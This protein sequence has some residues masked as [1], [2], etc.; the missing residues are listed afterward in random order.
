MFTGIVEDIGK[1]EYIRGNS[2]SV[3]TA[4]KDI[5]QGDSLLV[6]GVCLTVTKVSV[7]RVTMDI[8]AET[9]KLT[10]F[11][12][13]YSGYRINLES[14]LTLSDKIGGHFVYGHIMALG[15][16]ISNKL[17][18]NIRVISIKSDRDFLSKLIL[19]GSVAVNGVSLTVLEL[20]RIFFKVAVV[21]ETIKRTNLGRLRCSNVVNL[22]A[23]MLVVAAKR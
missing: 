22:E 16:V 4:I 23:D 7:Q 9:K 18:K 3:Y 17:S 12:G 5:K 2:I 21:P 8:G 15:R 19:K 6:D 14:S 1:I 20:N 11:K 10:S 13:L